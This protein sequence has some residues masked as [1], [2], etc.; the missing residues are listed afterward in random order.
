MPYIKVAKVS[1]LQNRRYKS[2]TIFSKK[3]AIFKNEDGSLYA[4]ESHCKHQNADL[5]ASPIKG[6]M[7]TCSRHGWVYN[8]KTGQCMENSWGYL[9]KF[10]LKIENED[11]FVNLPMGDEESENSLA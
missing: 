4:M 6:D 10:D 5:L 8:I 7:V 1:D 2:C 11:I 9:R 3:I